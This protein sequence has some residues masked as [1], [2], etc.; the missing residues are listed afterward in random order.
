VDQGGSGSWVDL[1]EVD[2]SLRI[3]LDEFPAPWLEDD[4][5]VSGL[6]GHVGSLLFCR[7]SHL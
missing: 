4:V 5:R 6:L 1:F 3:R 2:A 7:S